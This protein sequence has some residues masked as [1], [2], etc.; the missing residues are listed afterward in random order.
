MLTS[1][2]YSLMLLLLILLLFT[3]AKFFLY[4][5]KKEAFGKFEKIQSLLTLIIAHTQFLL[6]VILLF[7]GDRQIGSYYND[8]GALMKD[9]YQRLFAIEHPISMIIGVVLITIGYS[10]AKR[11]TEDSAKFKRIA[12]FYLIALIVIAIRIPWAYIN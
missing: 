2:H 10:T 12:V 6:G 3:A 11:M 7:V 9:S 4:S 1:I 5:S 8:M